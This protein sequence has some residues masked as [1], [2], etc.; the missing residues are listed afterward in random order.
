MMATD[1]LTHAY[2]SDLVSCLLQVAHFL[3]IKRKPESG[4][5]GPP[6]NKKPKDH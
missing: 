6:P 4:S 5:M 1:V 3:G 2:E